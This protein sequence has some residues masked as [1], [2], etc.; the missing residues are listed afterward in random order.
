MSE[1]IWPVVDDYDSARQTSRY[2]AAWAWVLGGLT[3]IA[4]ILAGNLL[5]CLFSLF[6]AATGW[7]IWK[8]SVAAS[9]VAFVLCVLQTIAIVISLPLMWA[10]V[11]P[12]AFLGLMNGVRGVVSMQKMHISNE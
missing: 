12:F 11:M 5:F 7:G 3:C 8:G 4:A 9:I 1:L 6:Y 10:V 2:G